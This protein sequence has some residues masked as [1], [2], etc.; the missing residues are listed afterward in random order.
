MEIYRIVLDDEDHLLYGVTTG[1]K[2]VRWQVL[3]KVV[4]AGVHRS[5]ATRRVCVVRRE[6]RD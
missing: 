5:R 4:I 2:V 6:A 3:E 1:A